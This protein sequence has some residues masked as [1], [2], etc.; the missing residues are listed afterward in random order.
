VSAG[1]EQALAQIAG[2]ADVIFQN[3]DAAGLGVFQAARERRGVYVIGSNSDQNA[4]APQVTLGSVVIDLPR[5]FF[6]LARDV[7]SGTFRPR[8]VTFDA[9][10]DVVRLV[11]N[12]V[13]A[14]QIPAAARARIDSVLAQIHAGAFS[15]TAR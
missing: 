9:K 8:V 6:E 7:K 2:G 3:A 15:A 10:S 1:K 5:A 11:L 13:L 14:G 4:L 12:P